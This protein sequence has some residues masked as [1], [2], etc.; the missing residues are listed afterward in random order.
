M[1]K[2]AQVVILMDTATWYT[3]VKRWAAHLKMGKESLDDDDRCGRPTTAK[4]EENITHVHRVVMDDRR[5]TV[6]QIVNAV[7]SI[8]Y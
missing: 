1:N 2:W 4:T 3:T 6:N 7:G 5:L 8:Y